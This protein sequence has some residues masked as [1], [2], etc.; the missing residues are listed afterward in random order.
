MQRNA[1]RAICA[2]MLALV[3]CG[4]DSAIS[5]TDGVPARECS[6][7]PGARRGQSGFITADS[8]PGGACSPVNIECSIRAETLCACPGVQGPVVEYVCRCPT[9]VWGCESFA[10]DAG[11]C[12]ACD[13]PDAGT[14]E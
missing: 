1:A 8:L 7:G 9:G 5:N 6:V 2:L 13:A 4:T 12:A 11:A 14:A 3:G 10:A